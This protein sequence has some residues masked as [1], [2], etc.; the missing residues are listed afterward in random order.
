MTP[1]EPAPTSPAR[2]SIRTQPGRVRVARHRLEREIHPDLLGARRELDA[3]GRLF[4]RAVR[5]IHGDEPF[6]GFRGEPSIYRHRRA[7]VV[8]GVSELWVLD[9]AVRP[10]TTADEHASKSHRAVAQIRMSCAEVVAPGRQPEQTVLAAIVR[11]GGLDARQHTT[12]ILIGRLERLHFDVADRLAGPIVNAAGNRRRRQH[13]NRDIA[14]GAAWRN[15]ERRSDAVGPA[16]SVLPFDVPGPRRR[17]PVLPRTDRCEYK[18]PILRRRRHVRRRGARFRSPQ[19]HDG[20]G[21]GIGRAPL[22]HAA[23]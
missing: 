13:R 11:H 22:H 5:K 7:R 4:V 6:P 15:R 16:L 8:A 19:F 2:R 12:S 1:T 17:D 18:R 20:L 9:D 3:C 23:L 10:N 21:N 14:H